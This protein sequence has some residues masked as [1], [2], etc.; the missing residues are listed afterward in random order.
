[1]CA[2]NNGEGVETQEG[3]GEGWGTGLGWDE[4][5]ENSAWTTIF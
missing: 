5:A 1:M 3:G 4:K 2:D